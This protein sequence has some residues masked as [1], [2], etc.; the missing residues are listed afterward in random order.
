MPSGDWLRAMGLINEYG[1]W[2]S[3]KKEEEM[4]GKGRFTKKQDRM[5]EHVAKSEQK[6]GMSPKDAKSIGYATVNAR[7]GKKKKG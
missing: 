2:I 1:F 7:K 6:K 3:P 5:A 4:P